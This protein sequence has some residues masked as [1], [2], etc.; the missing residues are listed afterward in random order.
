[1]LFSSDSPKNVSQL[2]SASS[3]L[4]R[5]PLLELFFSFS[6]P[7]HAVALLAPFCKD[8]A[9]LTFLLSSNDVFVLE[10][11]S[12]NVSRSDP[13]SVSSL[14]ARVSVSEAFIAA[15]KK[16]KCIYQSKKIYFV[17]I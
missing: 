13:S 5:R 1:M 15:A 8:E 6:P 4:G 9:C 10:S 2:G 7:L 14:L 16:D 12:V 17:P 3:G 11:S